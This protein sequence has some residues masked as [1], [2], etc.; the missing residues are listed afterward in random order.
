[1]SKENLWGDLPDYEDYYQ[2]STSGGIRSKDRKVLSKNQFGAYEM[3]RKGKVLKVTK[4][5]Q[6][7]GEVKL[8]NSEGSCSTYKIHRIIASAFIPNPLEKSQVNHIDGNKLNNRV[9]NLEWATP[10]ENT[11]HAYDTGLICRKGS[12]QSSSVLKECDIPF[13]RLWVEYGYRYKD[14]AEAFGVGSTSIG[15]IMTKVAWSHV[16]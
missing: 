8:T 2:V 12:K 9:D 6:G 10:S 3:L 4:T 15:N 11:Q 5:K 16:E 13:I 14:I 7:Y 1:M